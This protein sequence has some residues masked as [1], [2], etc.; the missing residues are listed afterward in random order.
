ME[1]LTHNLLKQNVN[2][3]GHNY[4]API[5]SDNKTEYVP[6]GTVSGDPRVNE[7]LRGQTLSKPVEGYREIMTFNAPF[8]DKGKYYQLD[9][10]QKVV[11]IPKPGPT[12]IKTFVNVGSFNE[13]DNVRGISHFIEHNLFNG[14]KNLPPGAFVKAITDMGAEYN[15]ATDFSGTNYYIVSPLHGKQDLEK[16]IAMH[17]D[18]LQNP[19]FPEEQIDKEKSPV[20]SEIHMYQDNPFDCAH[21]LVLKN[22]FNI[23]SQ[24]SELVGGSE[25]TVGGITRNDIMDYYSK[26]YTPE[27]ML[28]VIVGEINPDQAIK[29]VSKYFNPKATGSDRPRPVGKKIYEPLTPLQTTK[30]VDI[31]NPNISSSLL[32]M[33]FVGPKNSDIRGTAVTEA[34]VAAL[35]GF[36][37][38]RLIQALKPFNTEPVSDMNI[39]STNPDDPQI[40]NIQT[41]FN[42][43]DS[44][45][46]LH[47]IYNAVFD[48]AQKPV[49]QTELTIIKNKM[50]S[51]LLSTS[52]YS[53]G[54]AN[55]V[56]ESI[57]IMEI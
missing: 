46:G 2:F 30:R 32:C 21:N 14:S 41:D 29:L 48:L 17:A 28:T 9:N 56:A 3:S 10:G 13:P 27:N 20:M 15:A 34:L 16:F 33:S 51:N 42:P 8:Y 44:E 45:K 54:I 24:C 23:Q 39:I 4:K 49:S 11:I 1:V 57:V 26:W 36:N 19:T 25:K 35:T 43:A 38:G 53:M 55:M 22:L 7:A 37:N 6:E 52:E 12:T 40:I 50:K 31:K 18:M 5:S 47:S